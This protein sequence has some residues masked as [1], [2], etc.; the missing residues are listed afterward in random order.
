MYR[1]ILIQPTDRKYQKILW[2]F[3][4]NE[5]IK[6]YE[7]NTVTYGTSPAPFLATQTLVQLANDEKQHFPEACERIKDSFYVDDWLCGHDSVEG[8]SKLQKEVSAVLQSGHM[9]L[10][11]WAS[12]SET[13]L[14]NIP[15]EH[16]AIQSTVDMSKEESI[17]TLGVCWNPKSD[18][19]HFKIDLSTLTKNS[20]TKR[21]LLSD[22]AKLF[23]P[24]GLLSPITIN[25]KIM[26]QKV[27]IDGTKWD[28]LIPNDVRNKWTQ[29]KNEL[30]FIEKIEI[31]RWISTSKASVI[32]LHGFCD[33]SEAAYAAVIYVVQENESGITSKLV[34]A[35]TKVAPIKKISLPRLELCGAVLLSRLIK[36]IA[37]NLNVNLDSV[38]LWTDSSAVVTW[39][40]NHP[41]KWTTYIANRVSEVQENFNSAI[42]QHISTKQNPADIAS[43]GAFP[44]QLI[45][46]SLWWH[47]PEFLCK[48]KGNWPKSALNPVSS[49]ELEEKRPP[50]N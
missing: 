43:R 15:P 31:D 45:N 16:R 27:W 38:Y 25:A 47:G 41:S 5:P 3:S 23:D 1:Q 12:N 9:L 18:K 37:K 49:E 14:E 33:S 17:K 42:W 29:Y 2:R 39:L 24:C 46:N 7:L 35:K 34:C 30:P 40:R 36:R 11:K 50:I 13:I 4:E 48:P 32:S 22:S 8:A 20:F 6:T 19:L 10:R 28:E 21:S 26:M 44:S